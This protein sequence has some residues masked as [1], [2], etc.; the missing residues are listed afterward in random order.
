MDHKHDKSKTRSPGMTGA[1]RRRRWGRLTG[2]QDAWVWL[3]VAQDLLMG[4]KIAA[5]GLKSAKYAGRTCEKT[6][7]A[8]QDRCRGS[9]LLLQAT[10][11]ATSSS[12]R[13]GAVSFRMELVA[14]PGIN[15]ENSRLSGVEA[16]SRMPHCHW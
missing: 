14:L 12:R 15:T 6:Q 2:R 4:W 11:T 1:E 10:G 13:V 16:L 8:Q 5:G 3:E 7:R 9:R